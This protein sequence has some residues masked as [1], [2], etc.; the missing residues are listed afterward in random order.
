MNAFSDKPYLRWVIFAFTF[1]VFIVTCTASGYAWYADHLSESSDPGSWL[2]AAQVEPGYGEYWYKLGFNRQWNLSDTDSGQVISYLRHA[3][4]IDPRSANYWMALAGAYESAGQ[5]SQARDAFHTALQDYPSSAE[6]HWRFGSFLL[7]QGEIKQGYA[8]VHFGLQIDPRLIPLAISR[9]W[10]ATRDTEA[11]L[12][13]VLPNTA[14]AQQATLESFCVDN[15]TDA[16]LAVW[17]HMVAAHETI[18]IQTSFPL[19]QQLIAANRNDE[20]RDV[21]RQ[22]LAANGNPDEANTGSSLIFNG[23]FEYDAT[24]GGLDWHLPAIPGVTYDYDSTNAHS[25]KRALRVTF[26]G[27]Q[28]PDFQSITQTVL[29]QPNTRYHFEGFLRTSGVTTESGPRFFI[30]F[31]GTTLPAIILSGLTGNHSWEKQSAD[32]T[33]A[34]DEHFIVVMVYRAKS[35]RFNNNLAGTAWVDDISIVPARS[36][37]PNP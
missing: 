37:S 29:V 20:A 36:S 25:G 13:D 3:V 12:T 8:E 4:A 34:A 33:T 27:E 6:A 28:N 18:P 19:E 35:T 17:K 26:D 24:S 11:L 2:R 23:G 5:I 22:A 21:W 16:A 14:E 7:R 31:G 9:V 1:I 10:A 15:R 30:N 32:F